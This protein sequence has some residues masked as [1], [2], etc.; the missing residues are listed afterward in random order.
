MN[1]LDKEVV[2]EETDSRTGIDRCY[3][4]IAHFIWER[5]YDFLMDCDPDG[6]AYEFNLMKLKF[7]IVLRELMKQIDSEIK[8]KFAELFNKRNKASYHLSDVLGYEELEDAIEIALY[9]EG[10]ISNL[11]RELEDAFDNDIIDFE[12]FRKLRSSFRRF[13][14][15]E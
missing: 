3:F 1:L 11:E 4:A 7:H 12:W 2:D 8:G 10:Q 14:N 6:S 5:I 9:L 13:P 15:N